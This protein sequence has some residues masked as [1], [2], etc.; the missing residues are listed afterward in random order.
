M[1]RFVRP[2]TRVLTLGNGDTLV[3]K[4]CLTAGEQ[5]AA[6]ARMYLAGVNGNL[7]IHPLQVG[8]A[9]MT[10]YLVDWSLTDDE[11]RPVVIRE[12]SADRLVEVLESLDPESFSEI[13]DAIDAHEQA[14]A[15]ARAEE[16]KTIRTGVIESPQTS[17]SLVVV[18]GDRAGSVN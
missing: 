12:V 13:R 4:D 14:R 16:K 3:V 1:S 18:T 7:S 8:L 17:P 15:L 5:R 9:Q 10:A 11:G 6:Y 2:E